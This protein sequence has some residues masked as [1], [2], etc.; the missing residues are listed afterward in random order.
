MFAAAT[1]AT[2]AIGDGR[3]P[4]DQVLF[5]WSLAG[6][7]VGA[8][9]ASLGMP[10][11]TFGA[12]IMRAALSFFAGMLIAPWVMAQLPRAAATP[13]WWHAFAASGIGASL[14]YVLVAEGP[15]IVRSIIRARTGKDSQGGKIRIVPL[16]LLAGLAGLAWV[17]RGVIFLIYA[18][19]NGSFGH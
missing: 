7:A 1:V 14:V 17:C 6:T 8:G 3:L 2:A 16:V 19:L 11:T 12:R 10:A 13:D 5:L 15:S 4:A 9:V 18:M